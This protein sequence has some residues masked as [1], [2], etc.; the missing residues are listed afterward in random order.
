[1]KI[2][3]IDPGLGRVGFAVIEKVAGE[4]RAL[5]FGVITTPQ[6]LSTADRLAVLAEDLAELL[7]QHDVQLAGVEKLFFAKNQTT[8]MAVS[9]ARGVILLALSQAGLQIVE[10]SPPEVKQAVCGYGKADKCQVTEQVQ[11]IFKL[12]KKPTPDDAADALAVAFA[13]A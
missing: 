10:L 13:V 1:M 7:S 9:E 11:Q 4:F 6:G 12:E 8:A 2:L 3:G 5:D